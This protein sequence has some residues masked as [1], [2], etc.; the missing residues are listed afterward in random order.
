MLK[1]SVRKEGRKPA[2]VFEDSPSSA[3]GG[4]KVSTLFHL[5]IGSRPS[6]RWRRRSGDTSNCT[7][8][9]STHPSGLTSSAG[10]A[11]TFEAESER[12]ATCVAPLCCRQ[13][14]LSCHPNT[15]GL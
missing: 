13:M 2:L 10:T 15:R 9:S 7:R 6:R 8:P 3:R 14:T 11:F 5:S 4:T 1:I 12:R